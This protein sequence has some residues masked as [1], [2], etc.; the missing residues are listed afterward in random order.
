[1]APRA[2]VPS[3]RP[4]PL[5]SRGSAPHRRPN[6]W[7][8][9]NIAVPIR[10][11]GGQSVAAA[12]KGRQVGPAGGVTLILG[13]GELLPLLWCFGLLGGFSSPHLMVVRGPVPRPTAWELAVELTLSSFLRSICLCHGCWGSVG[14]GP[15]P[16]SGFGS[17]VR[18]LGNHCFGLAWEPLGRS[19]R[20]RRVMGPWRHLLPAS[21]WTPRPP[22]GRHVAEKQTASARPRRHVRGELRHMSCIPKRL[23]LVR[24][25]F[26][27]AWAPAFHG[28][29]RAASH[30]PPAAWHSDMSTWG[31][32]T[33]MPKIPNAMHVPHLPPTSRGLVLRY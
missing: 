13:S 7:A 2:L 22:T 8:V 16:A 23:T 32:C 17:S 3:S 4:R 5:R 19:W 27:A 12:L 10:L 24:D 30:A 25:E 29:M 28:S 20:Q 15:R 18:R 31:R 11:L 33:G 14:M 26:A 21:L 6:S 1:M 9:R